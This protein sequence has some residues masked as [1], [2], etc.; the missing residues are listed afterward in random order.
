MHILRGHKSL[1]IFFVLMDSKIYKCL[2][3]P[4]RLFTPEGRKNMPV[5]SQIAKEQSSLFFLNVLCHES[6][7]KFFVLRTQIC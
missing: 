2:P 7:N 4:A 3:T 1:N 5:P 6:L